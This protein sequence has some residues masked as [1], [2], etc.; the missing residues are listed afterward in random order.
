[1]L[2]PE[3]RFP[4]EP[5]T[6]ANGAGTAAMPER[7]QLRLLVAW[8]NRWRGVSIHRQW[9]KWWVWSMVLQLAALP[10][11]GMT[12]R[13][14]GEHTC[15]SGGNP[16]Q[17]LTITG[18]RWSCLLAQIRHRL[19]FPWI[20]ARWAVYAQRTQAWQSEWWFSTSARWMLADFQWFR[21]RAR[22]HVYE[23]SAVHWKAYDGGEIGG[24]CDLPRDINIAYLA[25]CVLV[26]RSG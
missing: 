14:V 23:R 17:S 6:V 3:P 5:R 21:T 24:D 1:M 22:L 18:E 9:V 20:L 11:D 2:L 26:I 25:D 15:F 7:R 13:A 12:S 10:M 19:R 8:F 4:L 16:G